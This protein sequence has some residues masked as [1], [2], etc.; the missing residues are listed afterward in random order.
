MNQNL[1]PRGFASDNNAG[2]H[3]D[4]MA[5]MA[6]VNCGH[7]AA[8]G[9]DSITGETVERFKEH[10][11]HGIDVYFVYNG[12]GANVIGLKSITESFHSIICADTAH[13]HVDECGAPEQFTGC[14][15]LSVPTHDGKLT[16]ESV[17]QHVHGFGF[18]HHAQPRVI[19]ITQAS[20]LG[21]VYWP[22]EIAALADYAHKN[23]MLLHVD[24]ARLANA[25]DFLGLSL[26]AITRDVGVDVLSFGGTKNGMMFGEAVV[27][28]NPEHSVH[29][30]YFQKQG[31]QLGSKM[32]FVSAQFNTLLSGDLWLEN[33]A[34][35]NRM[36]RMLAEEVEAIPS[37]RVTRKVETNVIFARVPEAQIPVL[38]KKQS[39]YVWN[40]A[41]SEV[42]WMT[43][44]DTTPEDVQAF[45]KLLK[46][47]LGH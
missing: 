8:Y 27:F 38:Q 36:A 20:E 39:F 4:I 25:A 22:E 31:M 3:P 15:L 2:V 37:V 19:S 46:E 11:G 23:S 9:E 7:A 47:T 30:R 12:T 18:V 10:F 5:A 44:F 17:R 6:A 21:T 28:F 1:N 42:R 14:K 43:S 45:V 16:V 34:H 40:D 41:A 13:L 24:G 32:R 26:G 35:A 29:T 33:A